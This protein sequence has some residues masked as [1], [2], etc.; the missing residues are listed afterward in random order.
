LAKP[1]SKVEV[2]NDLNGTLVGLYRHIQWHLPAL[3][4][5]IRWSLHSR[6]NVMEY[7]QQPG[8]TE[9]Q[10][11]S[12]WFVLNRISFNADGTSYAVSK[13]TGGGSAGSKKSVIRKLLAFRKRM[14]S[15]Q[16]ENI[17]YRR[18]LR[19]YDSPATF[20]FL[21]PP[22]LDAAPTTYDGWNR[23]QMT[24]FRDAVFQ[25]QGKWLVT[26]DDSPFN[27]E[28]FAGCQIETAE[29]ANGCVNTRLNPG[30]KFREIIIRPMLRET[31]EAQ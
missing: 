23:E 5:E 8:L 16:I 28:L 7:R 6:Q 21:D 4:S 1:K 20:F 2:V 29:S 15:V 19:L 24:E 18:F 31:T 9:I 12:R 3:L 13:T 11:V 22:Y 14:E 27:R 10:R 30:A 17:D 25:L 26:I